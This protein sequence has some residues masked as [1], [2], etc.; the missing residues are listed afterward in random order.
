MSEDR[1]EKGRAIR[2]ELMGEKLSQDMA[3][4]VYDDPMMRKF[5]DYAI[6]AVFA[7]LWG[8]PGLDMKTR[9]LICCVSDTATTAWPELKIHLRMARGQGWTE[10]EL[11][12]ALLHMAGYVGLPKVR[13]AMIIARE[14]FEE[15]RA[16]G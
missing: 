7:G 4:N 15:M 14:V 2:Q 6:D 13:E 5:G 3:A 1:M 11:S 8:R 12:E 16:E 9:A 10:D